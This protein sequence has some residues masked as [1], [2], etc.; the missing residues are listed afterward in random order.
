MGGVLL[1][2]LTISAS[3]AIKAEPIPELRPPRPELPTP[4]IAGKNLW[5]WIAGGV[6]LLVGAAILLWPRKP[7]RPPETPGERASREMRALAP[8]TAQAGDVV[9]IFRDYVASALPLPP[10]QTPQELHAF[11]AAGARWNPQNTTRFFRLFDPVELAKFA[12]AVSP[13]SVAPL[14]NEALNLIALIEEAYKSVPIN[15]PPPAP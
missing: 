8:S 11:L 3:A 7:A 4:A 6:V 10:G 14:I 15:R 1:A 2:V 13:P 12:P 5:P 9:R